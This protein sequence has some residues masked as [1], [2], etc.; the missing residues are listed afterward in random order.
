MSCISTQKEMERY[1]L[2]LV[3]FSTASSGLTTRL[4]FVNFF[5]FCVRVIFAFTQFYRSE[6]L[7]SFFPAVVQIR[8]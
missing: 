7:S 4:L 8:R 6:T 1:A 5:I 2:P 3:C